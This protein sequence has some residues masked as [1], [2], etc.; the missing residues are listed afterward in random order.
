MD[1]IN[2]LNTAGN[3]YVGDL[4]DGRNAP[5]TIDTIINVSTRT[6]EDGRMIHLPLPDTDKTGYRQFTEAVNT[7][8]KHLLH[9]DNVLVHCTVGC[10]RAPSVA[11]AVTGT[12][13]DLPPSKAF[14]TIQINRPIINPLPHYRRTVH[15]YLTGTA[16]PSRQQKQRDPSTFTKYE[17]P[18]RRQ[19]WLNI[20]RPIQAFKDKHL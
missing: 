8:I 13:T 19:L 18:I 4:S 6:Y 9:G 3:L 7:V 14:Y 16:N 1:E 17:I 20:K 5:E 12:L 15:K 10:N 11:A 2:E